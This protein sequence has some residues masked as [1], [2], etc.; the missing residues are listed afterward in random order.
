[1]LDSEQDYAGTEACIKLFEEEYSRINVEAPA[2]DPHV[3]LEEILKSGRGLVDAL[4]SHY[5]ALMLKMMGSLTFYVR[6]LGKAV[7][8]SLP[9]KRVR[10]IGASEQECDISVSSQPLDYFFRFTWGGQTLTVSARYS[11][12]RKFPIWLRHRILLALNNAELYLK[13]K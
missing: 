10:E 1:S 6:D 9:H 5:P 2:S 11:I 13:L 7:E 3:P 8:F 4:Y 12:R